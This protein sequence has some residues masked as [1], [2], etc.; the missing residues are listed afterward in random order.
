MNKRAWS[1]N[2]RGR[3]FGALAAVLVAA[4][5][6][7]TA[8]SAS[9]PSMRNVAD[10]PQRNV[11]ERAQAQ[12]DARRRTAGPITVSVRATSGDT[13]SRDMLSIAFNDAITQNP[14]LV[15]ENATSM[16]ASIVVNAH[17]R[18]LTVQRDGAGALAR[19]D[20]GVVV[21]DGTGAVRAM[22]EG[23]RIVRGDAASSDDALERTVLRGAVD[24]LVRNLVTQ[25][26]R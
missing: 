3:R 1:V 9:P 18:T 8:V 26:A 2:S 7:P 11:A 17:V 14:A 15:L 6:A 21:S 25:M 20:V 23:R 19:C 16:G 4:A 24:G 12:R 22:L 10:R 13:H 5:S